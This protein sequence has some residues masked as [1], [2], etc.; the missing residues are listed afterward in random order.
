MLDAV[1]PVS[2]RHSFGVEW[3][4]TPVAPLPARLPRCVR[5]LRTDE[6]G[7]RRDRRRPRSA[8]VRRVTRKR[9]TLLITGAALAVGVLLVVVTARA[10]GPRSWVL[11]GTASSGENSI[12]VEA[13]GW[14]Y[15]IPT[16]VSWQGSDGTWHEKGRPACLPPSED[17]QGP[18]RFGAVEVAAEDGPS[19]REVV[20]VRC[21]S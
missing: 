7:R 15:A 12:S 21:L 13:E 11:E 18:V 9:Q 20:W 16:D 19:W 4:L 1:M 17:P 2:G 3:G 5:A 6:C 14:T 8:T 10:L